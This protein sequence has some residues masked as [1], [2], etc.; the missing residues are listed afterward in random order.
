L[1][2]RASSARPH[3]SVFTFAT[4]SMKPRSQIIATTV[5]ALVLLGCMAYRFDRS[6]PNFE[7]RYGGGLA[8]RT[9]VRAIRHI[10]SHQRW[11]AFYNSLRQGDAR[12][13]R[14]YLGELAYGRLRRIDGNCSWHGAP[15]AGAFYED[16]RGKGG[17][18]Y[19]L[20]CRKGRWVF[21][22]YSTYDTAL[23]VPKGARIELP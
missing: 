10:V 4:V 22:G 19:E 20:V 3:R 6:D 15:A 9:D 13:L 21:V 14:G 7:V 5:A 11:E 12:R 2:I 16:A 18:E 8:D 17:T 23:F 1:Q